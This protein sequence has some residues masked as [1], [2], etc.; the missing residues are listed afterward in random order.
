MTEEDPDKVDRFLT[1]EETEATTATLTRWAK[2]VA[3]TVEEVETARPAS[4]T[5]SMVVARAWVRPDRPHP[6]VGT[7]TTVSKAT[8]ALLI[9][10]LNHIFNLPLQVDDSSLEDKSMGF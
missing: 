10:N 8:P 3:A 2:G 6:V 9:G 7:A 1:R 5:I 4:G